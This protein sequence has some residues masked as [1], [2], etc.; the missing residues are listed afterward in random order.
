MTALA[1]ER[2]FEISS[3]K[4]L[5]YH[6]ELG[7]FRYQVQS[8]LDVSERYASTTVWFDGQSGRLLGFDAPTGENAGQTLTTWIYQLHFA[9][10]RRLGLPQQFFVCVLG[11]AIATLSVT[12][13]WIW[14][15]RRARRAGRPRQYVSET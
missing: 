15:V 14:W 1:S 7:A 10:V 2:R 8:S 3:E 9:S 4:R 11:L 13:V 6:P 5:V 12:G